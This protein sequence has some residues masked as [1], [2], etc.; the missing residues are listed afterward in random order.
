[1]AAKPG[2]N[3]AKDAPAAVS[4]KKKLIPIIIGAVLVAAAAGGGA[5]FFLSR[6]AA[7][8]QPG[9]EVPADGNGDAPVPT[10]K[11]EYL[12]LDPPFVVNLADPGGD[13]YLQVE[14]QLMTRDPEAKKK[15]EAHQP[16]IRNRLLMLFSQ[17]TVD[18]VRTREAKEALQNDALKEVQDVLNEATGSTVVESVFFTSFVTQ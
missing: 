16:I 3:S 4:G 8:A 14:V 11:T 13:R 6:Q 12:A 9:A 10:G 5:A 15:I 17:Q 7:P 2:K 18:G 1:M